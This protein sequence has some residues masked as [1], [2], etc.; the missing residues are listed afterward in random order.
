MVNVNSRS[1]LLLNASY[2][3]LRSITIRDAA[4]LMMRGVVDAVDGVAARLHT[5]GTVFEVPS[6]LRL[7]YYVN[8]PRRGA[9]WSR[10]GVLSRD[11]FTC[12]YCGL[13]VGDRRNGRIVK[14]TDFTVDH[15]VPKSRGGGNTWSNTACACRWCNHRKANRTPHEAGMKLLWEPKRPRTNYLIADGEIPEEWK[16]YIRVNFKQ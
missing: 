3:P 8:V 6:V 4:D 1:V 5:P 9:V 2:V 14:R 7:R 10:R 16:V 15:L 11:K 13:S 12:V